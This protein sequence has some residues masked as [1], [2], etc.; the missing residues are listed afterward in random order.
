MSIEIFVDHK[1]SGAPLGGRG[2]GVLSVTVGVLSSADTFMSYF[3]GSGIPAT[4]YASMLF[5]INPETGRHTILHY[6]P[7]YSQFPEYNR[8]YDTRILYELTSKEFEKCQYSYAALNDKLSLMKDY[9][10]R[11]YEASNI[12]SVDLPR[13]P[14]LNLDETRFCSMLYFSLINQ[15]QIYIHLGENDKLFGDKVRHSPK[16]RSLLRVF[17]SFPPGIR[18]FLSLGYAIENNS[19]GI[20]WLSPYLSIIAHCDSSSNWGMSSSDVISIDWTND[21]PVFPENNKLSTVQ[22]QQIDICVPVI[23]ERYGANVRTFKDFSSLFKKIPEEID[24]IFRTDMRAVTTEDFA[25]LYRIFN[26]GESM[27]RHRESARYLLI[28]SLLGKQTTIEES[29]LIK[30]Y[31][32]LL[33]DKEVQDAIVKRVKDVSNYSGLVKV[34]KDYGSFEFVKGAIIDKLTS[35]LVLMDECASNGSHPFSK[36]YKEYVQEAIS[37]HSNIEKLDRIEMPYY[38]LSVDSLKILSWKEFGDLCRYLELKNKKLIKDI[39]YDIRWNDELQE[40]T[41]NYIKERLG[42]KEKEFLRRKCVKEYYSRPEQHYLL[43]SNGLTDDEIFEL[44]NDKSLSLEN[45]KDLIKDYQA[46]VSNNSHKIDGRLAGYYHLVAPINRKVLAD[47]ACC[48]VEYGIGFKEQLLKDICSATKIGDDAD[49]KKKREEL[50]ELQFDDIVGALDNQHKTIVLSDAPKTAKDVINFI[51][52]NE[53][54]SISIAVK[55]KLLANI[56]NDI[57][58]FAAY[59]EELYGEKENVRFLKRNDFNKTFLLFFQGKA[60]EYI[61][62]VFSSASELE[63][64]DGF[65]NKD[66]PK[67]ARLIIERLPKQEEGELSVIYEVFKNHYVEKESNQGGLGNQSIWEEALIKLMPRWKGMGLDISVFPKKSNKLKTGV[68]NSIKTHKILYASV[69]VALLSIIPLMIMLLPHKDSSN[70]GAEPEITP[71]PSPVVADSL[72]IRITIG[73][74]DTS[75]LWRGFPLDSLHPNVIFANTILDTL[76]VRAINSSIS[77]YCVQ[78]KYST[79]KVSDTT[80]VSFTK[81]NIHS[82]SRLLPIDSAFRSYL[83]STERLEDKNGDTLVFVCGKDTILVHPKQSLLQQI[84]GD[85]KYSKDTVSLVIHGAD[86]LPFLFSDFIKKNTTPRYLH[87]TDYYLWVIQQLYFLEQSNQIKQPQL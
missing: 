56:Y 25:I 16:L 72:F 34:D 9:D 82:V 20:K 27:Y 53:V 14:D 78:Y 39:P 24:N 83:E 11:Y 4:N 58:G 47:L 85:A 35:S 49:F 42:A 37:K 46:R 71:V 43:G 12:I 64:L 66:Y 59:Y 31:P 61:K 38:G 73:D 10:Q 65:S 21:K 30:S 69:C 45:K 62:K 80:S 68:V 19:N 44:L 87:T 17:D 7:Q 2:D 26:A 29:R 60:D 33:K 36:K 67:A 76:Y 70:L 13:R 84:V 18:R 86:T 51:K 52:G 3:V 22:Q 48:A 15:K 6:Q 77:I 54:N 28:A 57:D 32:D 23:Q 41:F 50:V 8:Y 75:A 74:D 1:V 40:S 55:Y 79:R 63:V 5:F 81:D